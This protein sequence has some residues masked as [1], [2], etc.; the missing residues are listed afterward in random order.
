[1]ARQGK[2]ALNDELQETICRYIRAGNDFSV[3]AG[4][5]GISP[6]T[7]SRWLRRGKKEKS[8]KYV[9]FVQAIKKA[10]GEAE[11]HAVAIIRQAMGKSWQA[12]MTWLERRHPERWAK[13]EYIGIQEREDFIPLDISNPDVQESINELTRKITQERKGDDKGGDS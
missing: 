4:A 8:G 9:K 6:V 1:M 12:A 5:G 10:E 11:V 13:R 7:L 3:A 2:E